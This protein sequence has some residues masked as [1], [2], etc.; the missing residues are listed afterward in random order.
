MQGA[1]V[2]R[3][4]WA[5]V[6]ALV[7]GIFP[8]LGTTTIVALVAGYLFR[9]NQPVIHAVNL[10]CYPL[11]IL[12]ILPFVRFGEWLF[13][14]G[15]VPFSIP[16]MLA[17]FKD[18]PARFFELYGMTC[19]YCIAAWGLVAPVLGAVLYPAMLPLVRKLKPA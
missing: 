12:L 18:S 4:T 3:L 14:A 17:I 15:P 7:T 9:L 6:V 10:V 5:V 16:E 2:E 19:L 8:I 13:G 11:H 1:S